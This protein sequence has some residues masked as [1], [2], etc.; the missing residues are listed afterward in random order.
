MITDP[1]FNPN[2]NSN[3]NPNSN[4]ISRASYN[5]MSTRYNAFKVR[6]STEQPS[7][8]SSTVPVDRERERERESERESGRE[9]ESVRES[10]SERK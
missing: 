2:S 10:E 1:D 6:P 4:L 8:L 7:W 5:P 9:S 3:P